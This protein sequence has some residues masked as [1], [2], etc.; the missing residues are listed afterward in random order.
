MWTIATGVKPKSPP[1]STIEALT[2]GPRAG[3][4]F[5]PNKKA[6]A[7]SRLFIEQPQLLTIDF[8]VD[9]GPRVGVPRVKPVCAVVQARSTRHAFAFADPSVT[10]FITHAIGVGR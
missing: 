3:A 9:A 4:F 6:A 8:D 5:A 10:N 7:N 2:I 1:G